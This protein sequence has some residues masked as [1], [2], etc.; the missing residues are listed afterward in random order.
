MQQ[1]EAYS[2]GEQLRALTCLMLAGIRDINLLRPHEDDS[3]PMTFPRRAQLC[4][5]GP[6]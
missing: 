3:Q 5:A 4:S 1:H 6:L 2:P